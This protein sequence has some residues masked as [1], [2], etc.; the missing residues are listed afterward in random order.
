M[1]RPPESPLASRY[2]RDVI[3]HADRRRWHHQS[4]VVLTALIA[5]LTMHG[6]TTDHGIGMGMGMLMSCVLMPPP[7][8]RY[9]QARTTTAMSDEIKT[10]RSRR[11]TSSRIEFVL[12]PKLRWA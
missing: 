5:L 3:V 12:M 8:S 6:L 2:R 9:A 1:R 4:V 7:S 10:S 11:S